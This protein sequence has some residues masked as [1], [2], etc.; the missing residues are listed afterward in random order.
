MTTL[1][2]IADR[3]LNRPLLVT[4]DKAAVILSVLGGRIGVSEDF[5]A[6]R[7]VGDSY[8]VDANG[9][10]RALPYRRTAEGVGIVSITGSLVNRGAWVGASSGLQSYEGIKFQLQQAGA[11]PKVS[12]VILDIQS[13]GGEAIGAFET[14]QAVRDLAATKRTVAVV[15]GMAASAAYAIASGASEIVTTET[16]VSGSIGVILV[17]ADYSAYLAKEGVKPTMIFAGAH[18]ADGNPFE[19]LGPEVREDL[20]GEVNALYEAFLSTV[21]KGRGPRLSAEAARGTEAR[22]F[23]GQAAVAAGVADRVGTFESVLA[24][25][26]SHSGGPAAGRPNSPA[27]RISMSE[28]TG[29][30]AAVESAGIPRSDHEAAVATA[31][32][33]GE[34]AG[35]QAERD[36]FQ[37]IIGAEGVR[38]DANRMAAALD[39]AIQSPGMAAEA[40]TGFVTE[41]VGATQTAPSEPKASLAQRQAAEHGGDLPAADAGIKPQRSGLS[42]SIDAAVARMKRD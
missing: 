41:R 9:R 1:V 42:A 18:K 5:E 28:N 31:R 39:L 34:A 22:V 19:A 10:G 38:G 6:S 16:G 27:R 26:S 35:A 30:S 4:R 36:R 7:F 8:E 29:T 11:D 24:E 17:H 3:L 21:A 25:L 12:S 20:Q 2:H 40:V 14:A 33:E 37:A 23:I 32:R 15:N 13:P